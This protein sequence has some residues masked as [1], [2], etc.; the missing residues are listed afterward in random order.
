MPELIQM[1]MGAVDRIELIGSVQLHLSVD[2]ANAGLAPGEVVFQPH[3][4]GANGFVNRRLIRLAGEGR[5]VLSE[6]TDVFE[7]E[8][9]STQRQHDV[10]QVLRDQQSADVR[11][12]SETVSPSLSPSASE[13]GRVVFSFSFLL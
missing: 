8:A 11:R 10:E 3:H 1:S 7:C 2:R 13:F 4:I 5:I 9:A 6:S 12:V